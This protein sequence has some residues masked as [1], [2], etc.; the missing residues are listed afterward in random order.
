MRTLLRTLALFA[1]WLVLSGQTKPLLLTVGLIA[2]L[3]VALL[4]ARMNDVDPR[5]PAILPGWP[6]L[7]YWPWLLLQV[8]R[9]N[10][11]MARR[12]LSPG[13]PIS[14]CVVEVR[15]SQRTALGRVT[16]ANSITLTPGTVAIDLEGDAIQVHAISEE[17]A[18]SVAEGEMDRRIT[19]A[20]R[21]R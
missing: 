8:V 4:T 9:S 11:D 7:T 19:A 3:F 13:L 14:P 15:A 5:P 1:L 18:R 20:E 6:L 10:L 21:A 16:Y 12:I 2:S 17:Q